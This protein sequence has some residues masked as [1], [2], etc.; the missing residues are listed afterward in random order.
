MSSS[1]F[2]RWLSCILGLLL[3]GTLLVLHLRTGYPG[4]WNRVQIGMAPS[5]VQAICGPPTYRS[6]MKPD[7]WEV[8]FLWGKWVFWVS[9]GDY[10]SGRPAVVYS[11]AIYFDHDVA[12]RQTIIRADHPPIK[13]YAA[14][15]RAFGLEPDNNTQYRVTQSSN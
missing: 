4:E 10:D 14:F 7:M 15:V 6:G 1:I 5:Q 8:P 9:S 11:M 3:F 2:W 13:D 12:G